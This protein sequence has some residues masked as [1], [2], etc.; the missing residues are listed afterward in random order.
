MTYKYQIIILISIQ[1]NIFTIYHHTYIFWRKIRF[2]KSKICLQNVKVNNVI[3]ARIG[4]FRT[5]KPI[6]SFLTC[7]WL[8]GVVIFFIGMRKSYKW[9]L[10]AKSFLK[11]SKNKHKTYPFEIACAWGC[12]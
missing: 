3:S 6:Y 9:Y 5:F 8:D 7:R 10:K 11:I 2:L 12:L 4:T 1:D